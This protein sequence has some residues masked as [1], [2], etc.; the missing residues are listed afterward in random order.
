MS[1]GLKTAEY[2]LLIAVRTGFEPVPYARYL[3][4]GAYAVFSE[5]CRPTAASN[6][7]RHLTFI[8]LLVKNTCIEMKGKSKHM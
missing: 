6:Q 2:L 7:F 3:T 8:Y 1:L 4:V 5:W